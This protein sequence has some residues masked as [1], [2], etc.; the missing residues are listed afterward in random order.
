MDFRGPQDFDAE[1]WYYLCDQ[2]TSVEESPDPLQQAATVYITRMSAKIW[3]THWESNASCILKCIY[4]RSGVILHDLIRV[5]ERVLK[6][7]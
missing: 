4:S 6:T 2:W 3:I 7:W 1:L 5:F